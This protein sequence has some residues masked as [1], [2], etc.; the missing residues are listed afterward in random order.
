M[1]NYMKDDTK[2]YLNQREFS[3]FSDLFLHLI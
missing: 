3:R 1:L 2:K